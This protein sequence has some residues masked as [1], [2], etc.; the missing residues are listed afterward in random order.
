M[1]HDNTTYTH[2]TK[3]QY[4]TAIEKLNQTETYSRRSGK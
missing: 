4:S 1:K 3:Y 2:N